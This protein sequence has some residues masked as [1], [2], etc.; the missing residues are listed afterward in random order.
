M[1]ILDIRA[2]VDGKKLPVKVLVS[3]EKYA[4]VKAIGRVTIHLKL[5]RNK[6]DINYAL[7]KTFITGQCSY[8]SNCTVCAVKLG[9]WG[10][11]R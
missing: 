10:L 8:N 9:L 4:P 6:E 7:Y 3:D 5:C 2:D 11:S 1:W